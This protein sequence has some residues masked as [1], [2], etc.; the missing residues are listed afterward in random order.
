MLFYC[1]MRWNID[2]RLNLDEFWKKEIHEAARAQDP[3]N[4][5]K[6]MGIWKVASQRRVIAVVDAPSA[7]AL[8][9]NSFT[10]PLAEYLEFEQ[11]WALR[12]YDPFI[13]DCKK[14]FKF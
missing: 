11:V 2:G 13:E 10:L 9:R 5:V 8:D 7:D 1:Q 14:G 3:D 12:D 6:L 4:P